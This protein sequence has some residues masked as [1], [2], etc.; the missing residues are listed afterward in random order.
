MTFSNIQSCSGTLRD[1]KGISGH[2]QSLLRYI[3]PYSVIFR[4]VTLTY[5]TVPYSELWHMSW[6]SRNSYFKYFQG[7]LGI[8]RVIDAYSAALTVAQSG[9]RRRPPPPFF[10]NRKKCPD[11]G[12]KGFVGAHL[13]A[14]FSTQNV[15]LRVSRRKNSKMFPCGIFFLWVFYEIFIEVP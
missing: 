7:H 3:E 8:F 10:E 4:C 5:T 14:K 9:R 15:A 12:K 6:P 13:W 11:F 1:I 2:L